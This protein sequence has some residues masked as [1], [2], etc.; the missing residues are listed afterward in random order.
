MK[1][2]L[3]LAAL[4]SLTSPAMAQDIAQPSARQAVK[5][6]MAPNPLGRYSQAVVTGDMVFVAGQIGLLPETRKL[7]EGG[8]PAEARQALTNIKHILAAAGCD[9]RHVV[10]VTIFTTNL[11]FFDQINAEYVKF[12]DAGAV[13]PARETVQV[14]RIPGGAQVEISVIAKK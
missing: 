3:L 6:D 11:D 13:L 8:I 1:Q 9:F 10:K 7:V 14:S 12:F 2:Y 5:T 4:G